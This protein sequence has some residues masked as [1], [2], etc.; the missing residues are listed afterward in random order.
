MEV[1]EMGDMQSL[2]GWQQTGDRFSVVSS[3][4]GVLQGGEEAP[5]SFW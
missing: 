2:K 3:P 4:G 1:A 5:A